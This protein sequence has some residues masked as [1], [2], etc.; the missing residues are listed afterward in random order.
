M[1]TQ[2]TSVIGPQGIANKKKKEYGHH[3]ICAENANDTTLLPYIE[4]RRAFQE[5][6]AQVYKKLGP[7]SL[8]VEREN[9]THPLKLEETI[10]GDI[11]N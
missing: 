2:L 11:N 10:P 8:P 7:P 5:W 1:T 9:T 6:S 4:Y 3:L